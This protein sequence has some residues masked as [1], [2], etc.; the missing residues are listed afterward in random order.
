MMLKNGQSM[1]S[2][3]LDKKDLRL[4]YELSVNGRAPISRIAKKTG[5]SKQNAGYRLNRLMREG[6]IR[7][8]ITLI[9]FSRFGYY[10]YDVWVSLRN[11]PLKKR[12]EF[13]AHFLKHENAMWVSE[14]IGKWDLC[15]G[16]FARNV[17][18]FYRL[19]NEILGEFSGIIR[20]YSVISTVDSFWYSR[21]HIVED[22][23][24][25]IL[26]V[27]ES[28]KEEAI[29]QTEEKKMLKL[30]AEDA[31]ITIREL[32]R[33]L[34]MEPATISRKIRKLE[35]DK[36]IQGYHALID[37]KFLGLGRFE[38]M[39]TLRGMTIE[40]EK[41]L[42]E[43]CRYNPFVFIYIKYVG[44]WDADVG[45]EVKDT[46][47]LQAIISELRG[48]LPDSIVDYEVLPISKEHRQNSFPGSLL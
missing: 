19:F 39:L 33:M 22:T 29:L 9:D 6:V 46:G 23:P 1:Q 2:L 45:I 25:R 41:K 15:V 20:D 30:M 24:R 7:G 11:V 12:E 31:R 13:I 40:K 4:L 37:P 47:Q 42:L 14:Y 10:E 28:D 48:L 26:W 43:F 16:L 35:K 5:L 32:A 8:F 17:G 18:H 27:W 3:T 21:S 38:V 36:I 44:K 34:G